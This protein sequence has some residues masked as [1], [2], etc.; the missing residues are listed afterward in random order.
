MPILQEGEL[1]II[2]HSAEQTRRLGVRLGQLLQPGDVVC[3]S[4]D[5]GAGKTVFT[6]GIGIG[7]GSRVPVTSP[8]F[9]LVQQYTRDEDDVILYHMDCYR[10][11]GAEDVE[12]IGF[13]DLLD[14]S[15][16]LIIEWPERIEDALPEDVLWV[17]IHVIE[18]GR[19]NFIFEAT[20]KHY[21]KLIDSFREK[22]FGF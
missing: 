9:N 18:E 20:S 13:D 22:A 10:L 12:S 2:S 15:G 17:D 4:G 7:W 14:G 3:L 1:D 5:L 6:S 19:R 21:Q 8:T 16:P 11:G